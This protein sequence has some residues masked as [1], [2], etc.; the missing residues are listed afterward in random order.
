MT[1][2]EGQP[3]KALEQNVPVEW[4]ND[5]EATMR[6]LPGMPVN[7]TGAL[8]M[9]DTNLCNDGQTSYLDVQKWGLASGSDG[10]TPGS[11]S[12][13]RTSG[14]LKLIVFGVPALVVRTA[15]SENY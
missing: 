13:S 12:A 9:C 4:S 2:G 6:P 8:C 7:L 5:K 11:G 10:T 3:Q 15:L 1:T 14:S